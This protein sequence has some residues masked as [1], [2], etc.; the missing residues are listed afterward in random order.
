MRSREL[1]DLP[2]AD[3]VERRQ[4]GQHRGD[5]EE[6]RDALGHERPDQAAERADARRSGR[7]AGGPCADR[8]AR[9]RSARTPSRA[10]GRAR[11]SA[12]RRRSAAAAGASRRQQ[13]RRQ[14]QD[15]AFDGK[16]QR[17]ERAGESRAQRPRAERRRAGSRRPTSRRPSTGSGVTSRCARNSASRVALPA[18]NCAL[19]AAAQTIAMRGG[20]PRREL[21]KAIRDSNELAA[22]PQG[23]EAVSHVLDGSDLTLRSSLWA[24]PGRPIKSQVTSH[25]A[26]VTNHTT[27][28]GG[29]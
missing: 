2:G 22:T 10:S 5:A 21:G 27:K 4:H 1:A 23:L 15:T 7:S 13:P 26:Q 18:M 20:D 24:F 9:S 11:R 14:Q 29:L 28:A 3:Q 6:R 12:D 16:G 17:H 25:K 8:S 19:T